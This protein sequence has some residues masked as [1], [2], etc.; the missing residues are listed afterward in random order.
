MANQKE[1]DDVYMGTA[2]LHSKLS[3][4]VRLK[5]GACL[6]TKSGIIIP[7]YN[8]TPAGTDNSC[9]DKVFNRNYKKQSDNVWMDIHT[10]KIVDDYFMDQ[11]FPY[12]DNENRYRLVTKTHILHAE[13]NC[14]LKAA[15]EGVSIKDAVLYVTHA[16]CVHC[17]SMMIQ[18]GIKRVVYQE[19]YRLTDGVDML[20]SMNVIVERYV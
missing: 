11:N 19:E 9:E 10:Y 12:G 14:I 17:S 20:H 3:K 2:I 13:L 15:K 1:L 5:V 6:V 4:A 18:T 8:G 16:P 7:G